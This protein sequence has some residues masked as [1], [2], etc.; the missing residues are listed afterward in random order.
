MSGK[1]RG[2]FRFL[3]M[4]IKGEMHDGARD[5]T[6]VIALLYKPLITDWLNGRGGLLHLAEQAALTLVSALT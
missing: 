6:G 2:R 1:R 4:D 5:A 3:D